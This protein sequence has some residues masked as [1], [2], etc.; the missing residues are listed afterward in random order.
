MTATAEGAAPS[1]LAVA[2]LLRGDDAGGGLTV[3]RSAYSTSAPIDELTLQLTDGSTCVVVRKDLAPSRKLPEARDVRPSFLIDPQ[4]EIV[5][6]RDVLPARLGCP[7]YLGSVIDPA[8]D[9]YWL[10]LER[11]RG[12]V[13]WQEGDFP[14][15]LAVARWLGRFHALLPLSGIAPAAHPHLVTYDRTFFDR[16]ARLAA[17]ALSPAALRALGP[18]LDA[19]PALVDRLADL[20]LGFVHGE[21]FPSNVMVCGRGRDARVAVLDWEMAGV[22]TG[23]LDVAAL[24]EGWPAHQRLAL[25]RAYRT[26]IDDPRTEAEFLVDLDACRLHLCLRWSGWARQWTPPAEHGRDWVALAVELAR[27]LGL[28]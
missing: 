10:L 6:Y 20:P 22:G 11:V 19:H 13:L 5:V 21:L 16:W 7:T 23:L 8:G 2:A 12:I 25:V 28:T 27:G 26:E 18:V 3:R 14:T 15:W 17:D 4:R 24:V 9:R 1:E